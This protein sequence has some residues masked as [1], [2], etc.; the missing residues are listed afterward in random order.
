MRGSTGTFG[1]RGLTSLAVVTLLAGFAGGGF[2]QTA[3]G[4]ITGTVSDPRGGAMPGTNVLVRNADTGIDQRPVVTNETGVYTV[5][6]LPPGNYDITASQPGF[7]TVQRKGVSLQVGQTLRIDF[8]MPVAAQES[9]VTVTTEVPLLE[10]ER[11]Q[12]AQN[13]NENMVG[14]LPVSSRRWEQFTLLTPGVNPDGTSGGISFHGINNLYNN[15]SVDGANNNYHYDGGTRG[16]SANDGYVY[17]SDSIR[18][19]QVSSSGF[20]AE[21]GQTA[22]GS[23]NAVTK[24][25]TNAW[26]GDAFYY[27]RQPRF[28]ALDPTSKAS[29]DSRNVAL[30]ASGKP[31][32]T[33]TQSVKQQHQYGA[34]VGGPLVKDKLFFF[35]TYD[36]Y[37]KINPVS[38][39]SNQLTPGIGDASFACPLQITARECSDTKNYVLSHFL[40]TYAS[41]LRQDIELI[42]LD[43][44]LNQSNHIDV[45]SNI[46]DW[47]KPIETSLQGA[48]MAGSAAPVTTYLQNRFVIA[49]WNMVMGSN[50]VNEVRFQY[51]TDNSF[52]G[53]NRSIGIPGVQLANLFGYG[54]AQGGSSWTKERRKQISDNFSW[55]KGTHSFK[56]GG[57]INTIQDDARSSVNSGGPYQYTGPVYT[58]SAQS[59]FLSAT[60]CPDNT[61]NIIFCNWLLDLYGRTYSGDTKPGQHWNSF[62]QFVDL[63]EPG[64]PS[65]FRYLFPNNDYAFFLNDTW[66]L[67]PNL[68][69]NWGVRYDL[70]II[71]DLPNTVARV[72]AE[73]PAV[74][75]PPASTASANLPIYQRYTT[76]YP[77][78]YDAIQPR[79]GAAWNVSKNTV[80]R[81]G[82]G[83]FFAKTDGHNIKNVVSGAGE[84]TTNCS[85]ST[86]A[87]PAA[88]I[89]CVVPALKFPQLIANQ[90][91]GG[92]FTLPLPGTIAPTVLNTPVTIPDPKFGIR[93]VDPNLRRPR[94]YSFD[95]AVERQL[96]WNMNIS[97]AYNHTHGIKL[98]RGR[99]FNIGPD[100]LDPYFCATPASAGAQTCG[101]RITKSYDIVDANGLTQQS[102]TLPFYSSRAAMPGVPSFSARL[103]PR[104]G[105]MNG[106]SSDVNSMYNGLV[107][108]VRKPMRNGVEVLANYTFSRATDNG[109]QSGG[110]PMTEG[111]VGIPAIDPFN[112]NL[113]KGYSGTDIR[114]RF[115]ASVIVAPAWGNS[116]AGAKRLLVGNWS[117]SSTIIAQGGQA[118][119]GMVQGVTAPSAVYN[120]Y[121]PGASTPATFTYI[122]LDGSMGGAGITSP[123]ANLAGRI[124][125][126]APGG[127]KLPSLYDVDLRLSKQF[128]ITERYNIEL[129]GEAFNVFNSTLVQQ[130]SQSAYKYVS[131]G[132]SGCPAT[133]AS[134]CMVPI[135]SFGQYQTTSGNL[136]G[137]RQLQAGIRFRF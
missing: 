43:Y 95:F 78:E 136:F 14:N 5:P 59:T 26:H 34:S 63:I 130:V 16:G 47:K 121:A 108:T 28:N 91:N 129:R 42:K 98:P 54:F 110:T 127:F 97:V 55:T 114:N 123:G 48:L 25:G 125:W 60:G 101:L 107:L 19:F 22:G 100:L 85:N 115:S 70:Q 111:Q 134:T 64:F 11:T 10:T 18:E 135:T 15:N 13:I 82:G 104:T 20:G 9:L 31:L 76:N 37:R 106:N 73:K 57:D 41:N 117:L 24:S 105:V 103:D 126:V 68:T 66:K 90:Q 75:V 113:E 7:A 102:I 50:K 38:V 53:I 21:V 17:S 69:L 87:L 84:T 89:T 72:C 120:G 44:Q 71:A 67:R 80:I 132:S 27:G 81:A 1:R 74:C 6:L 39:T 94:V 4:T 46:R 62:N 40:G 112:N 12:P 92:L 36:G 133:H 52:N 56:F 23:V 2:G 109:Q 33:A 30:A 65:T 124:A 99:D 96:P 35:A 29:A 32:E 45:V 119:T 8:E 137:A 3:T 61:A 86:A 116:A 83:I 79:L 131:P 77:N 88:S 118:Y 93:S 128:A 58:G 122:P 51:G 49:H